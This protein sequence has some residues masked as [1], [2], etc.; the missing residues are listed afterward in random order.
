MR[1]A[2]IDD[3]LCS[4]FFVVQVTHVEEHGNMSLENKEVSFIPSSC[5]KLKI[6]GHEHFV[7]IPVFVNKS[8]IKKG[9][10]LLW[11]VEEDATEKPTPEPQALQ[12]NPNNKAN[13]ES[14]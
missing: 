5:S 11:F 7:K 9:Q 3:H 4:D 12:L 2:T 8:I 13:L 10:E 1:T 14:K 6:S